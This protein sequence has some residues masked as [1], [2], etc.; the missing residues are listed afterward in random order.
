M[1]TSTGNSQIKDVMNLIKK[2][3]VRKERGLFVIEGIRMFA[4]IPKDRIVKIYASESFAYDNKEMLCDYRYEIVADNVFKTMSDTKTPQGILAVVKMLEYDIEDL[5]KKDKVPML[6]VLE[7]IQ[8]PG[9]LGTIIRTAEGAGAT[10]IIMSDKTVDIYNPK[11]IRST[12]G[13]LFRMPFVYSEDAVAAI[14]S[15]KQQNIKVFA[16]HLEG[17]NYYYEEDMKVPMAVLIGNEGNGLTEE[18][19]KEADVRI[20]IPMEGKLESLNAAVSTAVIL[21]EAMRQRHIQP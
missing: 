11:T 18:L 13:S 19:S 1:I 5:F 21:Y 17:R 15:L 20:K 8:D 9:N 12:M 7:N 4:E 2:S 16:A 10:G 6:V 14:H 3:G